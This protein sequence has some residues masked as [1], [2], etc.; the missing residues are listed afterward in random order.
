M[1]LLALHVNINTMGRSQDNKGA[2][3]HFL[4]FELFNTKAG[5]KRAL[6]TFVGRCAF[7]TSVVAY[8]VMSTQLQD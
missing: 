7:S 6:L 1:V 2:N 3:H 5:G 4:G 8:K